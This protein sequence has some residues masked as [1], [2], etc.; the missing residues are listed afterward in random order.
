MSR[1]REFLVGLVIL[2]AIALGVVGTLWLKGMN[3]GR[4]ST[5]VEVLLTDVARH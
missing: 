5:R 3:W 4:P 2:A 1:G